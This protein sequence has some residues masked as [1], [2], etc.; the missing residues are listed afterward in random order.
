MQKKVRQQKRAHENSEHTGIWKCL[1]KKYSFISQI[2]TF[3]LL[4]PITG[5]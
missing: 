1:K 3:K 2:K 5:K 4:D